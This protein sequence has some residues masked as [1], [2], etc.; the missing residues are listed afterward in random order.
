MFSIPLRDDLCAYALDLPLFM[1]LLLPPQ[2]RRSVATS[3]LKLILLSAAIYL[4][5]VPDKAIKPDFDFN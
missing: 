1:L 3:V 4:R 5:G 2:T